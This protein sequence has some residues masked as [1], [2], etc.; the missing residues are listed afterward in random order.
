MNGFSL[1]PSLSPKLYNI[2]YQIWCDTFLKQSS[3][4]RGTVN[5][6]YLWQWA[7]FTRKEEIFFFKNTF[8]TKGKYL[9]NSRSTIEAI[10][11]DRLHTMI[12]I[13][14]NNMEF[15]SIALE[16][17]LRL[18][19]TVM[20][21]NFLVGCFSWLFFINSIVYFTFLHAMFTRAYHI[22]T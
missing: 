9:N 4:D 18:T 3:T 2:F 10:F 22:G 5:I 20:W 12:N 11:A 15:C 19:R 1:L 16:S 21:A 8:W 13:F 17:M 6:N 14:C 7:D